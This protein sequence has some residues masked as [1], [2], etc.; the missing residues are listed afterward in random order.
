[1]AWE[2]LA[3]IHK[4]GEAPPGYVGGRR[5]GNYGRGGEEKLPVRDPQGRRIEYR[6]WDIHPRTPGR[7]RGPER[8]VTGN[9]GRA[10]YTGDHYRTFMEMRKR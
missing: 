1:V 7:N 4:H 3:Y 5:F 6:E 8:I 10:W 9:D 2:T